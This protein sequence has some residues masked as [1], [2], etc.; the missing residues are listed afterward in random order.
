MV[1]A[2]TVIGTDLYAG[3]WFTT[4]G[5]IPALNIA[6]CDGSNWTALGSGI[7]AAGAINALI[8]MGNNIYATSY[9]LDP[10][11]GG[12]G[13]IIA[14][15]D[16]SSWSQFSSMNDYVSSFLV[17]GSNLYAGGQF[18]MAGVVPANHIAKWDGTNWSSLGT[19]TSNGTNYYIG[20]TGLVR[21][22]GKLY[23]GGRFTTAGGN[24][25][26]FIANWDGTNWSS[27]I[28]G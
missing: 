14:K 26:N 23:V 10:A 19:G 16:G 17:D 12:P 13:N 18:T 11:L 6:K 8:A 24:A 1:S 4:A 28:N 7:S 5:G 25:A 27:F 21:L 3:G 15:W 22:A 20:G 2:L 9:I